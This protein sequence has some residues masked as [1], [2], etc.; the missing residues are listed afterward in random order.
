MAVNI[1]IN[2]HASDARVALTT[3][4]IDLSDGATIGTTVDGKIFDVVAALRVLDASER[5]PLITVS[6]ENG[7]ETAATAI[8]DGAVD[9]IRENDLDRLG[10]VVE[11]HLAANPTLIC[12]G[13]RR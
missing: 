4:L 7:A 1:A 12:G 6:C 13:R 9:C 10:A 5:L 8:Q 11:Q 3:S 2:E